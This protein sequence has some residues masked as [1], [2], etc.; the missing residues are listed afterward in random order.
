M[1]IKI[2]DTILSIDLNKGINYNYEFN[3]IKPKLWWTHDL[4]DPYLYDLSID[5]YND[6]ILI[7]VKKLN[8]V[9][10]PLSW[11]MK[12]TKSAYFFILN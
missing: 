2:N 9:F 5:L 4:G 8:M 7:Q 6:S 12:K 1:C 10:E 3:V 11:S